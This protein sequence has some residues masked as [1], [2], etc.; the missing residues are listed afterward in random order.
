[1]YTFPISSKKIFFFKFQMFIHSQKR[2]PQTHLKDPNMVWDFFASNPQATHQ[3]KKNI[4][5]IKIFS[6]F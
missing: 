4:L 5:K 1:M 2:N 6:V 3:V